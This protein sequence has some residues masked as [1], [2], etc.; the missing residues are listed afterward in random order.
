[1]A[2]NSS[3]CG[4]RRLAV[5]LQGNLA[6][7]RTHVYQFD[8]LK[9]PMRRRPSLTVRLSRV[10]RGLGW[11]NI[12]ARGLNPG[13]YRDRMR[14]YAREEPDHPERLRLPNEF[15]LTRRSEVGFRRRTDGIELLIYL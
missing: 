9:V 13:S 15:S 6:D 7:L 12:R 5:T 10:M 11:P 8:L 1:M 3:R 14:G 2:V 4:S